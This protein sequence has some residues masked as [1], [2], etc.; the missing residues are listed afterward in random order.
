MDNDQMMNQI[1][2]LLEGFETRINQ[3]IDDM[4]KAFDTKLEN[5]ETALLT[6]YHSYAEGVSA[7]FQKLDAGDAAAA[8][9]FAALES[10]VL[11][12]ET[13]RGKQ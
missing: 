2:E 12:L 6:E 8:K 11:N 7:H 1:Q 9:R 4:G 5:L 10:R 3:R 13:K